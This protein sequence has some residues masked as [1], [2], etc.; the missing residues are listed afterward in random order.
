[1]GT[2]S[3]RRKTEYDAFK[4]ILICLIVLGH[5]TYFSS[6]YP[7]A[8][9]SLYNFHVASFLLL[10]FLFF[11][12]SV[13][14]FQFNDRVVRYLVP[15]FFFFVLACVAYF[16][17]FVGKSGPEM[18]EWLRSVAVAIVFSSEGAYNAACGF[19]LFWFLP[20]LLTLVMLRTAYFRGDGF[21]STAF[22]AFFLLV[23][24]FLGMLPYR[25]LPYIPWGLPIV[26]FLF[27]VG[28]L[29]G[30]IWKQ[31]INTMR[32]FV[33]SSL[34]FVVCIAIGM[35]WPSSAGLAGDP[36]VFAI[37]QPFRLLFH[38]VYLVSA[39]STLLML[40]W[41]LP[42]R[43]KKVLAYVGERSLFVFLVHS[44]VLQALA[45]AGGNGLIE[46]LSNS[47]YV[48]VATSFST[49]LL[50]TLLLERILSM[51]P[52]MYAT[53]FPRSFNAWKGAFGRLNSVNSR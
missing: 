13:G 26:C 23:H 47:P 29:V 15:H 30:E 50:F 32:S 20:A 27:P 39:F 44:F 41:H 51:S 22:L 24:L 36:L 12:S 3:G 6:S 53:I 14:K 33:I 21:R 17:L 46:S 42:K 2:D 28:L 31:E 25:F 18:A 40:C 8:F 19:R 9:N 7:Q 45:R 10:P 11:G 48:L 37:N 34:L 49:T 16:T 52:R 43:A 4:G 1:M 35:K 38:D 5:D